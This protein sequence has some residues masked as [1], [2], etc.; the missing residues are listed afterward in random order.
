MTKPKRIVL[1]KIGLDGHDR[2]IKVVA[3]G[4]RDA[5]FHVIYAGLWQSPEAVVQ[6]VADEDADWLGISMLSGAHMTQVPQV[7]DL[8][9]TSG[10]DHVG[11]IVGGIIPEADAD[12]LR[13]LGVARVFGPGTP[14]NEIADFLRQGTSRAQR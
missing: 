6:A 4:L 7:M 14:M 2:G 13:K 8:L 12:A 9:R 1:A 3:R 5:G 10:L 11:V